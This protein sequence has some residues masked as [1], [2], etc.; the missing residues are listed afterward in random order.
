MNNYEVEVWYIDTM[1]CMSK[2][3]ISIIPIPISS[4]AAAMV[5]LIPQTVGQPGTPATWMTGMTSGSFSEGGDD[6]ENIPATQG[7]AFDEA[8]WFLKKQVAIQ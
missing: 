2:Y 5:T 6:P 1:N 8:G 7:S 3:I 4:I